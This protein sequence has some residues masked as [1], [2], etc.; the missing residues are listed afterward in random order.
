MT[1][2]KGKQESWFGE[3]LNFLP[4]EL[5]ASSGALKPFVERIFISSRNVLLLYYLL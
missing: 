5:E 1:H 2:K 3:E 4:G